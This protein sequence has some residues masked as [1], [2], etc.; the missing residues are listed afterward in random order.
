MNRTSEKPLLLIVDD[1]PANL[2][3]LGEAFK[4]DH[5]VRIATNGEEA[6]DMATT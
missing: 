5:I 2:R 6:L 4:D 3:I 1:M